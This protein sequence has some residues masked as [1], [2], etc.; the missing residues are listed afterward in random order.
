MGCNRRT[1]LQ[2]TNCP[3]IELLNPKSLDV[4]VSPNCRET[5]RLLPRTRRQ[6]K[7]SKDRSTA[8]C[9]TNR[10]PLVATIYRFFF[11]ESYASSFDSRW[12]CFV[13]LRVGSVM[14]YDSSPDRSYVMMDR[15]S[16]LR[17]E[18]ILEAGSGTGVLTELAPETRPEGQRF[19]FIDHVEAAGRDNVSNLRLALLEVT[20]YQTA[21]PEG[22]F[23]RIVGWDALKSCPGIE[24]LSQHPS[25][26][27]AGE[28]VINKHKKSRGFAT[29]KL[30]VPSFLTA[31]ETEGA[32]RLISCSIFSALEVRKTLRRDPFARLQIDRLIPIGPTSHASRF[33]NAGE[34]LK[35]AKILGALKHAASSVGSSTKEGT[36]PPMFQEGR[37]GKCVS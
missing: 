28:I 8:T 1:I 14:L 13:P 17:V 34:E 15:S 4:F 27:T 2:G 3:R 31:L 29:P 6:P 5:L 18:R 11:F 7:L 26:S 33:N 25:V 20:I 32:H 37:R 24:G 10:P 36:P 16:C 23:D 22:V 30:L 21:L 35:N 9:S 19:G 12:N